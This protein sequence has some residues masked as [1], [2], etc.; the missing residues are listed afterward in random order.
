[1]TT[2]TPHKAIAPW[3]K[4]G[5]YTDPRM[6]A[7]SYALLAPNA[8]NRQPWLAE[9]KGDNQVVLWRDRQRELPE[10]DPFQRQLVISLGCFLEQMRIAAAEREIGVKLDIYPDGEEGPAAIATFEGTARPDPLFGAVM[11]RRSCKK[12]FE[13]RPV[14]EQVATALSDHAVILTDSGTV[15]ELREITWKAWQTEAFH[16]PTHK[17]SLDLMRFGKSE[18]NRSPDGIDLGG[19]FLE[20]LMVAGVLTRED[21]QDVNSSGFRQGI[22]IYDEMLQA[23]PAYAV[24]KT[25]GNS[26]HHQIAAGRRWLRLNLATTTLG[27]AL[28]P[29]SQALQEFPEMAEHYKAAH[30]LLA[31][32]GETVQM[33]GRLGYGPATARTPRWPLEARLI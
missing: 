30:Q 22:K 5:D 29:V 21:Q 20:S 26:R 13:S 16:P 19:P 31:D 17:E 4:A 32:E 25:I 7:L 11:D 23:T 3:A 18:I 6:W 28:H 9:I 2:R 8:H 12:P 14:E 33:L 15:A 10:T 27:L 1:M 24:V